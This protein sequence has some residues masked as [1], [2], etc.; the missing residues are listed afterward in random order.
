MNVALSDHEKPSDFAVHFAR[1]VKAP[2]LEKCQHLVALRLNRCDQ[3]AQ[4]EL[5][6]SE[7]KHILFRFTGAWTSLRCDV[8][9]DI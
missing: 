5:A 9:P 1:S 7:K 6:L 4:Y 3:G 8:P 2:L